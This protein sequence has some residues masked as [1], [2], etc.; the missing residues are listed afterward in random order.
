MKSDPKQ[1]AALKL[2]TAILE[3]RPI[4]ERTLYDHF[5]QLI[6]CHWYGRYR[7]FDNI[8]EPKG[9]A[10]FDYLAKDAVFTYLALREALRSLEQL[11]TNR[12]MEP[13][14]IEVD[15]KSVNESPRAFFERLGYDSYQQALFHLGQALNV[16]AYAQ[17]QKGNKKAVLNKLNY[18]GMERRSI[19]LLADDLMDKGTQYRQVTTAAGRSFNV[20]EKISQHLGQFF[21]LFPAQEKDWKV[22]PREALFFILSGYTYPIKSQTS[23]TEKE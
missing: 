19:V 15:G 10:Q 16:A 9:E 22:D 5:T 6:L 2:F 14:P 3:K 7:A 17:S 1:N 11:K 21:Q 20:Q 8:T 23:T 12:N 13:Q 18:N 4:E